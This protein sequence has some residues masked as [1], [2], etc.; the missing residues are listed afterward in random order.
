MT[1]PSRR[2]RVLVYSGKGGVG[3]TTV[4]A[5]TA[6]RAA[7]LG[8]RTIVVSVDVAHS[9]ADAFDVTSAISGHPK[10][11]PFP[12]APNL[13]IQEI[14]IQEEVIRHWDEVF[15]YFSALFAQTGLDDVMAEEL[16]LIPGMEDVIALLYLNDYVQDGNYDVIVLDLAPTGESLR[17]VS[18]PNTLDWYM[19][20]V[21]RFE[22][23]LARV[24]RPVAK[25]LAGLP[26]PD[27]SYFKEIERLW[28]R[29][30]GVDKVL[31]DPDV[32]SVRLVTN[33][34]TMVVRETERAHMYFALYGISVDHIIVNRVLRPEGPTP[35]WLAGWVKTH[36]ANLERIHNS[37]A[38][39]PISIIPL[40]DDEVVG[41]ER[42]T[43]LAD[44]LYG[45]GDDAMDPVAHGHVT[46]PYHYTETQDATTLHLHLPNLDRR[47]LDVYHED[48]ELIVRVGSQKRHILLPRRLRGIAPSRT[49][50]E[51]P[52]L[53]VRFDTGPSAASSDAPEAVTAP[54][55][56]RKAT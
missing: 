49:R 39:I 8:H 34:E 3:K 17:F 54:P 37:F 14:D 26:L 13:D 42:L 9:L 21:F 41:L 33:A 23:N 51:A 48:E 10:G 28:K 16:A 22:R 2:P 24:A 50:Y 19:R 46:A 30:E 35:E 6:L 36:E 7:R 5:A 27:D 43:R 55:G 38:P 11:T 15:H 31:I 25:R 52:E 47:D 20:K 56:K 40:Q 45:T 32:T 53:L 18:M 44:H 12:V 1:E 29:M 4:A